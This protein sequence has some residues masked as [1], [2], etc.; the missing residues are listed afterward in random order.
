MA[1]K[2][3][4]WLLQGI[5]SISLVMLLPNLFVG[6]APLRTMVKVNIHLVFHLVEIPEESGAVE[7][8]QVVPAL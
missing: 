5:C 1:P 4:C 2:W 6:I 8:G 3:C 7:E